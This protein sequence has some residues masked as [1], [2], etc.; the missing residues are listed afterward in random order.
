MP[1][2]KFQDHKTPGSAEED[3]SML[4][5]YMGMVV[6]LVMRPGPF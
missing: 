2:A 3:F 1:N 5:P 6:I 4:L